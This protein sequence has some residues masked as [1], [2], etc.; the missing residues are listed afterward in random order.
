MITEADVLGRIEESDIFIIKR[1]ALFPI[2]STIP[3]PSE[4]VARQI[5][6]LTRVRYIQLLSSGFYFS[7]DY[8]LTNTLQRK[9]EATGQTLHE[10]GDGKFY[11]NKELYKDLILQGVSSEWLIPIVQGFIE[12]QNSFVANV[13]VKF[14]LISRRSWQRAGTRFH[15]RGL[16][17][18]GNVAN[19]VE[20]EQI[21][22]IYGKW[23]SYVQIRGSVPVFWQQTGVIANVELTRSKEMNSTA[24]C[25]H[26]DV[27]IRDYR[28]I[29]FINL[30]CNSK[31]HEKILSTSLEYLICMHKA[32]YENFMVYSYFDFNSVCK[33]QKFYKINLL[34]DQVQDLLNYYLFYSER[35]GK[36][37]TQQKGIV[38]VNCLDCLDRTNVVQC[39]LAWNSLK[40]QFASAEVKF[41]ID[42]DDNTLTHPFV[43]MFNNAWADNGDA[44]SKQYTG[45]GSTTSA[46]TRQG[47]QGFKGWIDQSVKS[48]NRFYQANMEDSY[49]QKTF[50]ILLNNKA[51][52]V[53]ANKVLEIIR[54]RETEYARYSKV[55]VR[56]ATWNM[57]GRDPPT[58]L[59]LQDLII[60]DHEP[61]LLFMCCQE[62]VKLNAKNVLQE[63]AN[64]RAVMSWRHKIVEELKKLQG[65]HY[66]LI[67]DENLVGC[68]IIGFAKESLY[69]AITNIESDVIK[70]GFKGKMGNKGS[71]MI[72]FDLYDT[73]FC[74]WNCHLASGTDQTQT[75]LTQLAD[76]E[77]RG[78]QREG[79]GR[80]QKYMVEN[81]DIKLLAGDLNFRIA[82]SNW[83]ARTLIKQSN[84]PYLLTH[85][86]L[87][88]S[89]QH[90]VAILNRYKESEICFPPTYKYDLD[91]DN[92]DTSKK[93]RSPAWC[94]R[95]LYSGDGIIPVDYERCEYTYS[96]HRPVYATF[97]VK[98]KAIDKQAYGDLEKEIYKDLHSSCESAANRLSLP[99]AS[100][101]IQLTL[102]RPQSLAIELT[103]Y[104]SSEDLSSSIENLS[105]GESR[106]SLI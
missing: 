45:A 102:P 29:T 89:R 30:L 90:N 94:D 101:G 40:Y 67:K 95:I 77:S 57:A 70:S 50:D 5:E 17:D 47:K 65:T 52:G 12:V 60:G 73:S 25:K 84:I 103:S 8:D 18:D 66:H 37:E 86:Q 11:W 80:N 75:R 104:R 61:D 3:A 72:R 46:V 1:V 78:F 16:D 48:I 99:V 36:T 43:K 92:Y 85:D 33:S 71:V 23:F 58:H 98:I 7:Y 15:T 54:K 105:L 83:E 14:I 55:V 49:K 22:N 81:H 10:K 42:I 87:N 106:E 2:D 41:D 53:I 88:I 32:K 74:V 13:E 9:K 39:R 34:I 100:S 97:E 19:F 79:I 27:L 44:L 51:S 35:R 64:M 96:D 69:R 76:I 20:T 63:S 21:V 31:N 82:M 56:M 6:N 28:H 62:I 4:P 24:F 68:F 59:N 38:R 91:T 26:I 93:Q